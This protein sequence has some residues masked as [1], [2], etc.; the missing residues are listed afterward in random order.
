M[1]LIVQKNISP[2]TVALK[3]R[4][5][6]RK[7]RKFLQQNPKSTNTSDKIYNIMYVKVTKIKTCQPQRINLTAT[8]C[9][10]F[11]CG[12]F[13]LYDNKRKTMCYSNALH[14]RANTRTQP[15]DLRHRWIAVIIRTK[16]HL[17]TFSYH[18]ASV[19]RLMSSGIWN[20][21][22]KFFLFF[23]S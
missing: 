4:K 14:R 12:K 11:L 10:W 7:I 23:S 1:A 3:I 16:D 19:W 15:Y 13:G 18:S 17:H 21:Q 9:A 20:M 2:T 8:R 5:K 22:K 6:V